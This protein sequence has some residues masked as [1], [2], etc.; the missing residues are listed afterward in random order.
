MLQSDLAK[1]CIYS[2]GIKYEDLQFTVERLAF[3][4]NYDDD[5]SEIFEAISF[6][7]NAP[8]RNK[9]QG[10][11]A[12]SYAAYL[13][14]QVKTYNDVDIFIIYTSHRCVPYEAIRK[15]YISLLDAEIKATQSLPTTSES[16]ERRLNY[17]HF[18][19]NIMHK[20]DGILYVATIGKVHFKTV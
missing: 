20:K 18:S 4:D 19:F 14:G 12:G 5:L 7:Y 6:E 13:A 8:R 2:K 10:V 3:G 1:S 11:I 15:M 17:L 9:V 16:R